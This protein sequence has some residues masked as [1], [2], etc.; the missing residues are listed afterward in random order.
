MKKEDLE[1]GIYIYISPKTGKYKLTDDDHISVFKSERVARD[2]MED[3][4]ELS[5]P[6][7]I[8]KRELIS[9]SLKAGATGIEFF[10]ENGECEVI[11]VQPTIKVQANPGLT[12]A[13]QHLKETGERSHLDKLFKCVFLIPCR[14]EEETDIIYAAAK[15]QDDIYMLAFTDLDEFGLWAGET[16]WKPLKVNYR[17]LVRLAKNKPIIINIKGNCRYVLTQEKMRKIGEAFS[18]FLKEQKEAQKKKN[19]KG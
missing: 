18:I 5:G 3:G 11:S 6:K 4:D 7:F 14:I 16:D 17:E 19:A 15:I 10:N 8:D 1:K 9:L 12:A 13:I 2:F